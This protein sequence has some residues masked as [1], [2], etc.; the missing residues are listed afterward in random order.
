M[1]RSI[2]PITIPDHEARSGVPRPRLTELLSGPGGGRM[3]R[4]VHVDDATSVVRQ[5]DE[6]EQ[7]ANVAVGTVKKSIEASWET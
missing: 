1:I 4:D 5:H 3:R 6:H 2:D 7:D